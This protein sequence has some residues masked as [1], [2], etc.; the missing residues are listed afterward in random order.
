[1]KVI[2]M[3]QMRGRQDLKKKTKDYELEV[4]KATIEASK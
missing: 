2:L 1:M 3:D 4:E